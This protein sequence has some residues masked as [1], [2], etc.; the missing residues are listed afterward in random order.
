M[1]YSFNTY[2]LPTEC[3]VT[4]VELDSL[5]CTPARPFYGKYLFLEMLKKTETI[6]VKHKAQNFAIVIC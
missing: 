5:R 2:L 6:H 4:T 3:K 1:I